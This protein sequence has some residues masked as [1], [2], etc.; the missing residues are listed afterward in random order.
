M[1]LKRHRQVSRKI[2]GISIWESMHCTKMVFLKTI[3]FFVWEFK[4]DFN[5]KCL[6]GCSILITFASLSSLFSCKRSCI[7]SSFVFQGTPRVRSKVVDLVLISR[8]G[9]GKGG[10]HYRKCVG[11]GWAS[12]YISAAKKTVFESAKLFSTSVCHFNNICL[13]FW[14]DGDSCNLVIQQEKRGLLGPVTLPRWSEL[15]QG[16]LV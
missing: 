12:M 7:C 2:K 16:H 1:C 11:I 3:K 5:L 14:C 15:A 4:S 9:N 6:T 10:K 8:H 13:R